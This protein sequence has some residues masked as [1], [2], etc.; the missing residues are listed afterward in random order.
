M[1]QYASCPPMIRVRS[2]R[3]QRYRLATSLSWSGCSLPPH[4]SPKHGLALRTATEHCYM[5]PLIGQG[6]SRTVRLLCNIWLLLV[7]M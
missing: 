4:G 7:P 5:R 3:R 6:T 1:I 2:Q